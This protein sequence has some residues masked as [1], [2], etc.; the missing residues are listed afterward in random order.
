MTAAMKQVTVGEFSRKPGEIRDL[1]LREHV[2]ITKHERP[3]WV[4]TPF[5][6]YMRITGQTKIAFHVTQLSDEDLRAITSTK[7]DA[8]YDHLNKELDD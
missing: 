5:E 8:K 1:A 4:L 3:T 6:D 7:M 2:T